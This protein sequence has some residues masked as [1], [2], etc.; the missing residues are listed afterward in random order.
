MQK[1]GAIKM[2]E[3]AQSS[4]ILGHKWKPDRSLITF[5]LRDG[6]F[7]YYD[8]FENKIVDIGQHKEAICDVFFLSQDI[9]GSAS[10]DGDVRFW[11]IRQK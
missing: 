10:F 5:G 4:E 11:D 3:F 6:S 2:F 9:M 8:P 7:K 1:I